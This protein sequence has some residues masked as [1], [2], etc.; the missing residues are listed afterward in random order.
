[1]AA[2]DMNGPDRIPAAD[3][4]PADFHPSKPT[5]P[6]DGRQM[7]L[8]LENGGA[9]P[10]SRLRAPLLPPVPERPAGAATPPAPRKDARFVPPPASMWDHATRLLFRLGI[11]A[12]TLVA[13]FSTP[14]KPRLLA[15]VETP[16]SGDR[17]AGMALR[18]G[19][20]AIAGT[21]TPIGAIDY[22]SSARLAPA[23]ERVIHGFTWLRDLAACAPPPQSEAAVPVL[24]AWLAEN[25]TELGDGIGKGAAWKIGNAGQRLLGWLVHAPIVLAGPDEMLHRRMLAN[26]V[27]TARWLDRHVTRAEDRQAEAMGYAALCAAGLLLP[28]G[29]PRR[30]FGEAGLVRALGEAV[31]ED[32]G[33][34]SRG[35][36][37]Q[38]DAIAM[39]IDLSACYRAVD[40]EVPEAIEAMVQML[41]PPLLMLAGADGSLGNWQGAGAIGPERVA[42]L[43]AASGVRARPL[44]EARRWGYQRLVAHDSVLICDAAPPPLA[45]HARCGCASTLAVEFSHGEHAL[46]VNCGGAAM[47]GGQVPARVEQGLRATAAHSTLVLGDANST[48]VL[49]A[50]KLGAG[51]SAVEVDRAPVRLEEGSATR[52]TLEHDGYAARFG[53]LHRRTLTL[54]DDGMELLGEDAIVPAGEKGQRGKI[55]YALRF[56]LGPHVD[57]RLGERGDAAELLL[58]D[59]SFWYFTTES[60]G[61]SEE[62]SLWIDGDGRAHEISQLVLEGLVLRAGASFNWRLSRIG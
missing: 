1:M 2:P 41:L 42:A 33:V 30:L 8:A 18:T 31:G 51:V 28:E 26:I 34:L 12:S 47:A 39:L 11:P 10:S 52:L 44:P 20:F 62:E 59:G 32:G 23:F 55:A 19:H 16:L 40:R 48:A 14:A 17:V 9:S 54:R 6:D 25:C 36:L 4:E 38:I 21:R 24:T 22:S 57:L 60:D 46:L 5:P 37:E 35:P 43:V 27:T 61:L 7:K 56:H 15:T 58:P 45:R 49:V 50:G 29:E 3:R 13:P 53:L